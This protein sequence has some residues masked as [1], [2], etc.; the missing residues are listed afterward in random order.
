[1]KKCSYCAEEV[2]DDA[3]KCK[4]CVEWFQKSDEQPKIKQTNNKD[5]QKLEGF[6][7]WLAFFRFVIV[8]TPIFIFF[9]INPGFE[10]YNGLAIFFNIITILM[11]VWLNYLM[12][13]RRKAFK[14][15]FLRIGTVQ[16][17]LLGL[18]ALVTNS[19]K[20]LYTFFRILFYVVVWSLYLWNSKRVRN[21]F[22]N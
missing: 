15:W 3:K 5:F 13:E 2:E 19:E 14:K 6:G 4:H 21:T 22:I 1:M 11:Y 18:F 9:N 10:S 17:V 20:Y 16:V 12:I 7:G 8:V